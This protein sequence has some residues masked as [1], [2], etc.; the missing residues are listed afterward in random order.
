MAKAERGLLAGI[1][2]LAR[3]RQPALQFLEPVGLSAIAQSGFEL[4][5]AVEMIIDRALPPAGNKEELL[6]P[7]CLRLLDRIM[8]ERLVNDRQHFLWH[9]LGRGQETRSQP[10]YREDSFADRSVHKTL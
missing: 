4:D 5:G 3:L 8:D 1:S 10:G 9:R 6:D 2:H 7:G